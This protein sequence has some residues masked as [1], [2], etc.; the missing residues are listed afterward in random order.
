MMPIMQAVAAGNLTLIKWLLSANGGELRRRLETRQI[1]GHLGLG[2]SG[3]PAVVEY[4]VAARADPNE[5]MP[6][7]LTEMGDGMIDQMGALYDQGNTDVMVKWCAHYRGAT[8]LHEA[9]FKGSFSVVRALCE[10][11]ADPTLRNDRGLSPA[12][13]ARERGLHHIA[14]ELESHVE[15]QAAAKQAAL[16]VEPGSKPAQPLALRP[17]A[18]APAPEASWSLWSFFEDPGRAWKSAV[19]CAASDT[20]HEVATLVNVEVPGFAISRKVSKDLSAVSTE[21]GS[22]DGRM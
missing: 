1:Q 3:S 13:V 17:T 7:Q 15:K 16:R 2:G 9:A 14:A 8:P 19:C 18:V 6:A 5:R 20:E 4:L 11:Q 21:A 10:S 22:E 12:D